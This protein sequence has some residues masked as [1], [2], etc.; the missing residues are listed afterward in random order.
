MQMTIA[1]P[2]DRIY[3]NS[4]LPDETIMIN[5]KISPQFKASLLEALC[6]SKVNPKVE[7]QWSIYEYDYSKQKYFRSFHTNDKTISFALTKGMKTL[8]ISNRIDRDSIQA[9]FPIAHI[10]RVALRA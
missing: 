9:S 7:A 8:Q 4:E 5:F 1:A 10:P 3:W 6:D 2:I